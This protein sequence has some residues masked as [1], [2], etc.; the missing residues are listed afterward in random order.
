[1]LI[2]EG[3]VAGSCWLVSVGTL[4][5]WVT[6]TCGRRSIVE[7]LGPGDVVGTLGRPH[8]PVPVDMEYRPEIRALSRCS[9]LGWP[10]PAFAGELRSDEST[11]GWLHVRT[12]ARL[13]RVQRMLARSLGAGVAERVEAVLEELAAVDGR[14]IRN[15]IQ[16]RTPITQD[17]LAAAA[18][19]TRET[20]NRALRTLRTAGRV[21]WSG[22]TY[23]VIRPGRND[24]PRD[25]SGRSF[26]P[27]PA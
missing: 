15:G 6:S 17:V 18:G 23:A 16:I 10:E 20:A 21:S 24:P 25:R 9:L 8:V 7:F 14:P 19:A 11:P 4:A 26:P 1:M 3:T 5:A 13:D 12:L 2:R 27:R 22:R